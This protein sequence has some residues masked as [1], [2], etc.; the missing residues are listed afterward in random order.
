MQ[1]TGNPGTLEGLFCTVL[2]TDGHKTGHF[3]LSQLNLPTTESGQGLVTVS[4]MAFFSLFFSR[5]FPL[6]S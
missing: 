6:C 2:A 3:N 1:A 5:P 4:T